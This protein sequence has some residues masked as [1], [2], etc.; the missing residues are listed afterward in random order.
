MLG[1]SYRKV[2]GVTVL[3]KV[4]PTATSRE[5]LVSVDLNRESWVVRLL[6]G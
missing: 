6:S 5:R 2:V 3:F 1:T 4:S